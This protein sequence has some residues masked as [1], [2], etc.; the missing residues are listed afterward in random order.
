MAYPGPV[1][2]PGS[3]RLL[4]KLLAVLLGPA[5]KPH[6]VARAVVEAELRKMV[7]KN[8]S[9]RRGGTY[10]TVNC[11][12]FYSSSRAFHFGTSSLL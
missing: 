7:K 5:R 4:V 12:V 1:E 8:I 10:S 2:N 3:G 6:L 9:A 11:M